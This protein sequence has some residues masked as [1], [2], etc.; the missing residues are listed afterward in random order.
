ME[1]D[2]NALLSERYDTLAHKSE[3]TFA[4]LAALGAVSTALFCLNYYM[5]NLLIFERRRSEE[6]T[7]RY[8][9][10]LEAAKLRLDAILASMAEGL[11]QIDDEGRIVFINPAGEKILGYSAAELMGKNIHSV[12][13]R[14]LPEAIE[15]D[16]SPVGDDRYKTL[17]LRRVTS[18]REITA[19]MPRVGQTGGYPV[20]A[21]VNGGGIVSDNESFDETEPNKSQLIDV[22]KAG[23]RYESTDELFVRKDGS[24]VPVHYVSSPLE[25]DGIVTGAVL[26]F[27]D[28]TQRKEAERRV[29]EFYST[30]S[31]E[32]RSPLTSIRGALGLMEGGKAGEF[33]P[34]AARLI[35]IAKE[36]CERLIRLINDILDIRKIEAGKLQLFLKEESVADIVKATVDGI[37]A[38]ADEAHVSLSV[39]SIDPS[40]QMLCDRDRMV[41]VLTNLIGNAVKFSPSGEAV[42]VSAEVVAPAQADNAQAVVVNPR[43]RLSIRDTGPGISDAEREKLFH[44]FQQ[45][46]SS[47]SRPKGGTG[48]GLAISK[49]LVEQHGG[50]I[51]LDSQV[52]AGS[53]FLFELGGGTMKKDLKEAIA[54]LALRFASELPERIDQVAAAIKRFEDEPENAGADLK[55]ARD[56][57]HQLAGTAGSY[58]LAEVGN[59]M[60]SIEKKLEAL[61][62]AS[63]QRVVAELKA[64][65][66]ADLE[67]TRS[68]IASL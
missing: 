28:V 1:D 17:S 41:Q 9:G 51:G 57:V 55:V 23:V 30:V 35:R 63:D 43:I 10:E 37:R 32:L 56:N 42:T 27:R 20:A 59:I 49:A 14:S 39:S 26:T 11:Y 60:V 45:L 68:L 8:A 24:V 25:H 52:G 6:E 53:T 18:A 65:L 15:S 61:M 4:L 5:T 33:S 47:D 64:D 19:S 46:D 3:L 31:H 40:L 16:D 13:H 21:A 7:R 44:V 38:M 50:T 62:E 67:Q 54:R 66:K 58:G 22:I 12:I 29:S 2:E 36:E 48:L 34:K